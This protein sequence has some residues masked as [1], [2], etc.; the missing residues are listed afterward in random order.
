MFAVFV[1]VVKGGLGR[2][3]FPFQIQGFLI[4]I[5]VFFCVFDPEILVQGLVE[6]IEF[7]GHLLAIGLQHPGRS[8]FF[9]DSFNDQSD[10]RE[11]FR[12]VQGLFPVIVEIL[13]ENRSA[14]SS[15]LCSIFIFLSQ[16]GLRVTSLD[17]NTHLP[18]FDNCC[19]MGYIKIRKENHHG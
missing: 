18:T 6:G 5:M 17:V 11:V 8:H 9:G 2:L 14:D 10:D 15:S 1:D 12:V 7:L 16:K 4:R 3:I 13:A 19:R